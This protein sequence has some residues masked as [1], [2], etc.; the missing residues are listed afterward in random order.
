MRCSAL[1][2]GVVGVACK[3]ASGVP[4]DANTSS[5]VPVPWPLGPPGSATGLPISSKAAPRSSESSV[6]SPSVAVTAV[7]CVVAESVLVLM[8]VSE[9]VLE[10][11]TT[12]VGM[13]CCACLP[14]YLQRDDGSNH[15][16]VKLRQVMLLIT[17]R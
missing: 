16:S 8:V 1:S 11:I 5:S 15:S 13:G 4:G 6:V 14:L 3:R 7:T 10:P 17:Q 2:S 12:T 9:V